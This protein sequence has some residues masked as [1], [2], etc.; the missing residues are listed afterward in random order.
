MTIDR[1]IPFVDLVGQ[2]R[3]V[4][5]DVVEAI[6]RLMDEAAFVGG[7]E[8]EAFEA[9]FAAF[10]DAAACVGVAN[11]TDAIELI[12]RALGVGP[13]D[14]VIVPT[15][16]F[17]A[18]AEA[19]T[20][21]GA[22]PVFVD[23]DPE[24]LLIDPVAVDRA[25]GP[26][27]RAVIGVDLYGQQAPLEVLRRVVGPGV[28]VVEDAAQ[29]QG[30]TRHGGSIGTWAAAAATSFYPGKNLGAYGD[31]GGVVTEDLDLA[32][33]IRAIGNHG[34]I[35]RYEHL[36][37]GV[38]S[39][40]DAV[41]AAVLR[42]KLRR[43]DDWN[44]ARRAAAARYDELLV[45]SPVRPVGTAPGNHH[46]HH[47][48]VVEVPASARAGVLAAFARTGVGAGI[49]YP[50]PIHLTPAFAGLGGG[51]GD[52]PV[53]EAASRRIVSLPMHPHLVAEDQ[54]R[55]VEVLVDALDAGRHH[56]EP[57]TENRSSR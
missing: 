24:H 33:R 32:G 47:L 26:A 45:G 35:G 48:Y 55:V 38:N 11:G 16:S 18:T 42:R 30:S 57:A 52:H 2:H 12:L 29:S 3:E 28:T 4:G 27:T 51:P 10:C 1:P 40:L 9:E 7:P 14:E 37:S 36:V 44:A 17:V 22:T 39:R 15:N 23:C 34:G 13:A 41:Q 50:T 5:D 46:V 8:V 49:H 53:A 43:L 21:S 31:A 19:V 56:R 20:R 6:T 54:E 25:L